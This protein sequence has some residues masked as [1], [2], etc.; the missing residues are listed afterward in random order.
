MP[1]L[2][3]MSRMTSQ[4]I[5][6]SGQILGTATTKLLDVP[7]IFKGK[8]VAAASRAKYSDAADLLYLEGRYGSR[9]KPRQ[10]EYNLRCIGLALKRYPHLEH[11]FRR[12]GFNVQKAKEEA[13]DLELSDGLAGPALNQVQNGLLY[14]L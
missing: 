4:S 9:I 10:K 6:V 14:G 2:A 12:L 1:F 5:S 7:L 3:T 11:A 13:E 8:L